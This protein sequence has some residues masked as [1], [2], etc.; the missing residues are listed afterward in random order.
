MPQSKEKTFEDKGVMA[1]H[2][3]AFPYS[4]DVSGP[5]THLLLP[6]H[7]NYRHRLEKPLSSQTV[8]LTASS[9]HWGGLTSERKFP[10]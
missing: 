6:W 10:L 3:I 4:L 1:S 2:T 8:I 5:H 9:L 7:G